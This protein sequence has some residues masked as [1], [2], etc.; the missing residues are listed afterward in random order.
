MK[1]IRFK[2]FPT[3][4]LLF[5]IINHVSA[6]EKKIRFIGV[7]TGMDFQGVGVPD[8]S[9]IRG[10][11]ASYPGN[12]YT[13]YNLRGNHQKWY[14]GVKAEMRSGNNHFGYLAGLRFTNIKSSIGKNIFTNDDPE[15]FYLLYKV[16]GTNTEYL[17]VK[18]INRASQYIGIPLEF[19][20]YPFKPRHFGLYFK[21]S[22]DFA[23][24]IASHTDVAFY[25]D[26][27]KVYEQD[28]ADKFDADSKFYSSLSFGVGWKI[29]RDAKPNLDLEASFPSFVLTSHTSGLVNTITGGGFQVNLLIPF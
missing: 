9:F 12:Y 19:R 22:A 1:K 25:N 27:M 15:Y 29:G 10:Q 20:V 6:Q 23:Y 4:V 13:A 7:E 3:L 24:L 21:A 16:E 5:L 11:I 8:Y 14:G 28:V 17:K 26:Q 18:E 2:I